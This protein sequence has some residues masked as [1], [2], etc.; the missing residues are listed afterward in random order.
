MKRKYNVPTVY[1]LYSLSKTE[2]FNH[3]RNHLAQR[4]YLRPRKTSFILSYS[5][6]VP[7]RLRAPWLKELDLVITPSCSVKSRLFANT[8]VIRIGIDL[9][10]FYPK[11][12]SAQ[13]E[14][15][16]NNQT[17][18]LKVG[19]FGHPSAYKGL[20]DFARA[21]RSLPERFLCFAFLS[22]TT[23]KI[24]SSLK[25]INPKLEVHGHLENITESYNSMNIIVLPYRSHLAGVANPLVLI[26]AMACQKPIITTD[27]SYLKEIVQDSALLVKPYSPKDIKDSILS[28]QDP[29]SR[30]DL[31]KKARRIIEKEYDQKKMFKE[32]L[33]L[34][35]DLIK[36]Y[37]KN[38]KN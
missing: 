13:I 18:F 6:I 15:Q 10:K 35:Q 24:I 11:E 31:G 21:T 28:L 5:A 22:D 30:E 29:Q 38:R 16:N 34:Y 20:L 4:Y 33:D 26:E 1:T 7:L 19:F 3:F 12:R 32:Y 8:K 27:F 36:D 23:P 25:K 37:I 14:H 17:K 2:P 9:Q